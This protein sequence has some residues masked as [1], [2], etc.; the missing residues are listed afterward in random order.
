M[1]WLADFATGF[2]AAY[3]SGGVT[4]AGVL[5]GT[6]ADG[7]D[8]ALARV[9]R[10]A[11]PELLAF[12]I[13]PFPAPL[14]A[15]LRGVLDGAAPT[16]AQVAR[17]DRALGTAFG[18][19]ARE[20]ARA[21]GA[22]IELLGSHGQTVWHHDGVGTPAS[23]QWGDGDFVAAAAGC[24]VVSDFRQ[25]DLAAGG[26]G[27]PITALVDALLFPALAPPAAVLNLGGIANLT[28]LSEPEGAEGLQAF[29]V[30]PA[31]ALLDGLARALLD[32]PFDRDGAAAAAGRPHPELVRAL[33]EHPFFER[34]PPKST[35]RD[36]FGPA[37]VE[38][39][40]ERARDYDPRLAAADVLASAVE[41]LARSVGEALAAADF[42]GSVLLVAG[43]GARNRALL[44]GLT[45]LVPAILGR[46]VAV[47]PSST[48]GVDP[49]ARE[50]L[51]FALLAARVIT[52]PGI[53]APGATGAREGSLLGKLS[54][55]PRLPGPRNS[56]GRAR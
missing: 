34:R 28:L 46:R 16:L 7:I 30:G 29:D 17:L 21:H 35:G 47:E 14:G 39:A 38:R 4:L 51:A 19:A 50:A 20:V 32:A 42:R 26:E 27:A 11:P 1:G 24:A 12:E 25:A 43:G 49:D 53:T 5:S 31:G 33:L 2:E 18:T 15:E 52:G 3:A 36:T 40:L 56:T 37:W 23:L 13:C 9:E 45:R 48:H 54:P 44:A 22:S 6:S 55:P 10:G 8:V 41:A